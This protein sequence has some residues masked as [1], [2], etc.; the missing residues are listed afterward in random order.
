VTFYY[1]NTNKKSITLDIKSEKGLEIFKKILKDAD[2]LVESFAP[3]GLARLGLTRKVIKKINPDLIITSI[4]AF[5]KTGPYRSYLSNN[6]ISSALGGALYVMRPGT[7]PKMRPVIQ[8]GFQAEYSTGLLSY[9]ATVAALIGRAKKSNTISID[10]S[11]MDCVATTLMG[12]VTEYSYLGLSRRT[13][14]FAIHG[15][16]IGNSV[17][18][19]DGWISLIPGIGGAPN[20]P[21]LIGKPELQ[22]ENLFTETQ[23]RMADPQKFDSLIIPWLM[24]HDK[25]EVAREAQELRLAITPVLSPKE[26]L[27]DPQLQAREF[28]ETVDHPQLGRVTCPGPPAKLSDTPGEAGRAPLLGEHNLEVYRQCGLTRKE[29]KQL[30]AEEVI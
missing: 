22:E 29:I 13:N 24:E 30:Q 20:I 25:W 3:G 8:G 5:G 28:F 15:Y 14:P 23:A 19:K 2:V 11:A 26:L 4:S 27:E 12:Q 1:L 16:P 21:F 9:I 7:K 10:I 17:P 18:C 6:L